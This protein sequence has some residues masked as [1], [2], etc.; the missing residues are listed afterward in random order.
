M[1]NTDV[2]KEKNKSGFLAGFFVGIIIML[3]IYCGVAGWILIKNYV[4]DNGISVSK[5]EDEAATEA[6]SYKTLEKLGVLKSLIEN[7]YALDVVDEK[8]MQTGIYKGY[9]EALGD[10]Y[11]EYISKEEMEERSSKIKGVY[12]GIGAYVMY[13]EEVGYCRLGEIFEDSPAK[14]AGLKQGDYVIK[15][16]G[17]NMA[18]VALSEV[19]AKIKGEEG[20]TV[21]LTILRDN[22]ADTMDISVKRG[23]VPRQTVSYEM[24]DDE[25]GY[26]R[27]SE[28][29]EVTIDQF[30]DALVTLKGQEMKGLIIDLRN[31]PGGNLDAVVEMCRSLLPKGL[32]VYTEDKN[33]KRVEY[34]NENDNKLDVPMVLLINK[35]SASASEIMSGA[36]KD[37]GIGTLIGTTTFGKGIVQKFFSLSDG[38]AVKLTSSKYYTPSGKNIHGIGIEPD[39]RV[40]LDYDKFLNEGVDT[41]LDRAK[42]Y[43]KEQKEAQKDDQ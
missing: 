24:L 27:I 42:E 29:D 19:V 40:E 4:F 31:N 14:E 26:I 21:V 9:I 37:Y 23:E 13:D 35:G 7:N 39:E 15:V 1:N 32:I 25:I 28:F 20:T 36:V 22:S 8:T 12:Y 43:I 17:E 16:D 34:T 3:I 30:T 33:G 2:N 5:K 18:G 6:V 41:Q 11:S 10:P 38:S